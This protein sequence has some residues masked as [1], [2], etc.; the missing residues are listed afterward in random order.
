MKENT[1][2]IIDQ[3]MSD[4]QYMSGIRRSD[5]RVKNSGEIFTP[6]PLVIEMMKRCDLDIFSSGKKVLDPAC[7]DGQFLY[8]VYLIKTI[9]FGMSSED[10]LSEIYGVDIKRD[11]V[12]LCK[13][14]LGGGNIIMGN[15]LSPEVRIDNQTEQEHISMK[16]WFCE[17]NDEINLEDFFV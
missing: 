11:N 5:E 10:A 9:K 1:W 17:D 7:G 2:K 6:S 4:H 16:E 3:R 12:D 15:A 14:R 8:A 13:S